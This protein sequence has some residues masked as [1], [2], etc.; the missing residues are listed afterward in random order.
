MEKKEL[1]F[2]KRSHREPNKPFWYVDDVQV[3][4]KSFKENIERFGL[5][6]E[7]TGKEVIEVF[8]K[9]FKVD[10]NEK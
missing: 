2:D 8:D 10:V 9:W 3:A 6:S 7:W 5:E 4:C 1:T